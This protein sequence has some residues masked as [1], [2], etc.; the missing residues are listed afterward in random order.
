MGKFDKEKYKRFLIPYL[1]HMGIEANGP[2]LIRCINPAHEDKHP[3]CQ[4]TETSF[5]CWRCGDD[6]SGDI[7][8]AVK[9]LTGETDFVKQYEEIDR[10]FGD[11]TAAPLTALP[12]KKSEPIPEKKDFVPN[13]E[14]LQRFTDFLKSVPHSDEYVRNYFAKRAAISTKGKITQ[15]P[16]EILS[17]LVTF[18]L[19]YPGKQP[20]IT[21]LGLPALWAAGLPYSHENGCVEDFGS[22]TQF[23]PIGDSSKK[24]VALNTDKC[25]FWNKSKNEYEQ[26]KEDPRKL[27]WWSDGIVTLTNLGYKLFFYAYDKEKQREA[28]NKYNPRSVPLL[29]ANELVN[30]SGKSIVLMEGE[31]DAIVCRASGIDNAFATGGANGLSKPKIKEYII[32]A[33]IAEI[34]LFADKDSAEKGFVGQKK[35]GLIPADPG[36]GIKETVP[37]KLISE[38][39]AGVIKVTCLPDDCDFKD[40]DEAILNGRF[41]LVKAAIE[42]ARPYVAPEKPAKASGGKK[43]QSKFSGEKYSE[44]EPVPIKFFRS[45]LK[46]IK[47]S[48]L[49]ADEIPHFLTAAIKACKDPAATSEL[50]TWAG[51]SLTEEDIA[52]AAKG[53][54]TPFEIIRIG[55]RHGTSDYLLKRLEE[56]LVPATEILHIIKPIDT[57]LPIDYEKMSQTDEFNAFLH[58]CDHAFAAYAIAKAL[59]GNLLY[60]DTE[61]ANYV[62]T[63]NYWVRIP[64][65]ATEAHAALTNALLCYLRN[66]PRDKKLV[67]DCIQKIGSNSFRQK[68]SN[69][70]NKKEAQFYHDE[71]KEPILFDSYPV[72]E[73]LTLQDGV[74]DFS[75][76]KIKF[77]K[78]LPE[79]Y[80]LVPM[81]YTCKDIKN[82]GKPE[83]FLKA[84]DLDFAQPSEETLKKNPVLTKDTLLYYLSLIPSRNVSKNYSCFM[85]GP[86]GTGKSTF[87][88]ALQKIFTNQN[89]A[90]LKAQILIAKKKAFDNENGPTPE[91]AELEGKLASI[92]MELPEDGRLNAD[93]LKR[94]TGNDLISARKL[95]QGLHKF[96]PT[97]QIIIVGNELPSFYKHD[98]GIIRRL[99]VFHFNIEHAKRIKD[100][101]YKDLYK[102]VP[103]DS[104]K[105]SEL[106][107]SEAPA[108]IRLLAEKYIE[109][110]QKYNLNIPISQ[111]CENA[112]SQY[113]DDQN[114]D[115][116]K[117]YDACIRFTPNDDKAF[118]FSRQLYKCYLN[119]NGFQEGSTEAL[120]QR[121]FIFYLKKDHPEL[122]GQNY[123]QRRPDVNSV[124]EWGFKFISF[125]DEG[126]EYLNKN[127]N[128]QQELAPQSPGAKQT[129]P[130]QQEIFPPEP[131]DNPFDNPPSF[132]DDDDDSRNMDIF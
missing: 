130:P 71:N 116:D 25:Y 81:P 13:P 102:G 105:L 48:E 118:I 94:L 56:I 36:D 41:D 46:K 73:T 110:K 101:Q 19:Y 122:G 17:K 54:D 72:R 88:S 85:T 2:G 125:T 4:L 65:I 91:I 78:G 111:E 31:M 132:P 109:L 45:L 77:R 23:P 62:F 60:I 1:Q 38:G 95:R 51:S 27:S 127:S 16:P 44:W 112:K 22:L 128:G 30:F 29:F 108:I 86:G 37:D 68:L 113:I 7:Y 58:F 3:S 83:F 61:E 90:Q 96:L 123:C 10:L 114:K 43:T 55:A 121:N 40:P 57:I 42:N 9:V 76:D 75:G 5:H 106:I 117:F 59:K 87:I 69:D 74:L 131:E 129:P 35:F 39:F 53:E 67:L 11:G 70:L 107:A 120:K 26:F 63:G 64:S 124:P 99:L 89:L 21:A 100:K 28:S 32:P 104:A 47:Y 103:G 14:A 50:I 84:L 52:E 6:C 24:Y 66:N 98:S 82:A 20:T 8:E 80:R 15:Y 93:E 49:E 126:L 12:Q 115:T 33:N 79:E 97:A 92:T 18:F 119:F 34:I